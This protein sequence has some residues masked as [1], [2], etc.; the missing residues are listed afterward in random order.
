M[1]KTF[2]IIF[3]IVFLAIGILGFVPQARD[4]DLLLGV[5]RIDPLHNIIHLASG[6]VALL[7][8]L[9]SNY[10]SRVY[11]QIFGIIYGLV[12]LLGFYFHDRDIFGVL[13]NNLADAVLHLLIAAVSLYLGFGYRN[14]LEGPRNR[15][16]HNDRAS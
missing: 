11:F 5:F 1:L 8:G 13:T 3:G 16:N 9:T 10:A 2:A 12:A 15:N 6:V 7:C 14:E 4:G